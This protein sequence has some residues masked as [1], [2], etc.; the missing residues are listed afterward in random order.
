LDRA[1]HLPHER[2]LPYLGLNDR[3][4]LRDA[5]DNVCST[6]GQSAVGRS[7]RLRRLR[8]WRF[9]GSCLKLPC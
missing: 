4:Q 9:A 1:L 8:R 7:G 5:N 6:G 3:D 2:C